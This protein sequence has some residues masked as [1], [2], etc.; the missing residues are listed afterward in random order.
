METQQE[1]PFSVEEVSAPWLN[2]SLQAAGLLQRGTVTDIDVNVLGDQ[3]GF[4]GE[5]VII[6]PTYST[7]EDGAPDS[8]VLKIPTASKN[9]IL[10]QTMGLYEKE[11]RFYRDLQPRL[12]IR[13]P[14]HYFSAL[15]I[16]DDSDVILERLQG[17]NRLP[18][19]VI[20]GIMALAS[21]FV[22]GHPR[23]YALLIENLS[24]YRMGDQ[25]AVREMNKAIVV[26]A[27]PIKPL[28]WRAT[29]QVD[30]DLLVRS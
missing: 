7:P 3:V 8:L 30:A 25:Q 23:R 15:D 11:I 9:R 14:R 6:T 4:N 17:M 29:E 21:R 27:L 10:G 18:I 12:N 19:W 13:T 26:I 5:V 24:Q 28:I 16:A 1:V 22:A 2:D 20:R